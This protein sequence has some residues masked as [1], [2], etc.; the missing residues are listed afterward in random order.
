MENKKKHLWLILAI[1]GVVLL[2]FL[3]GAFLFFK[4]I[5]PKSVKPEVYVPGIYPEGVSFAE[6]EVDEGLSDQERYDAYD[7]NNDPAHPVLDVKVNLY[8]SNLGSRPGTARPQ[9]IAGEYP[10]QITPPSVTLAPTPT[11][12]PAPSVTVAPG[13]VVIGP[14]V[15]L[16]A[17]EFPD[18]YI[19][20]SDIASPQFTGEKYALSWEYTAG[21]AVTFTV[22][23]SV[24]GGNVF[25]ELMTGLER[26]EYELTF[27]DTPG[28][29]CILRVTAMVDSIEYLTADTGNFELV[30]KAQPEPTLINDY[31]DPQV[32]YVDLPDIRISS[33]SGLPVWFKIENNAENAEKLVW[34]LS[35]VPFWGT[36]ES[37]GNE[38]GIIASGNLD[39][40]QGGEFPVDLNALCQELAKPDAARSP[41]APF[42]MKQ[43]IYDFY[44]RVVAFDKDGNCIGDPGRGLSFSYG[45]ADVVADLNSTSF[46]DNSQISTLIYSMYN[47][48]WQWKRVVPGVLNRDLTSPSD[49]VMFGGL[50]GSTEGSDIIKRAVQVELQ[51]ATSP[52]SNASVLGLTNPQGLVYNYLDT[53][54]DIG[55]S[56]SGYNYTTPYFHGLEYDKFVPSQSDLEAMGGIYYYVRAVFYVP[57]SENPSILHPYPSETMTVAFRVTT[58][59][60]NQVEQVVV[61]SDIPFVEF[62]LYS[63][64]RW[65]D[66]NSDEYFEVTRHI[67]A[68]EMT[69][70][71]KNT[72]TGD[73]LLP[74]DT[75]IA[76]YHW[77][78]EQ[79]QAKLDEMLPVYASFRY[80][81]SEPAGFWNEFFSLLEAIYSSVQE[82]YAD[83]KD[84]VV[85]LVDYIPL[86]GDDAKGYLKTAIR[87]T[88]D[89]GLASIGLPPSL[90]NLDKLAED[91]LD[92]CLEVAVDEALRQAGVPADSEA[93]KEITEKVREEVTSGLMDELTKA[94]LAQSQNP[95]NVDFLRV[96]TYK[97]YSPAYVNVFVKNYSDT[98]ESASGRL[99][100]SFGD[101]HDRVYSST[102]VVI[103]SLMPGDSMVIRVYLDHQRYKYVEYEEYFNALYYGTSGE[104]FDIH[105]YTIFDLKDVRVAAKE[106]GL[107]PAPLPALTEYVYD[108][109]NYDFRR[110]FIPAEV[111]WDEDTSVDPSDYGADY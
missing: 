109:N 100:M 66:P 20:E 26:K 70:S 101:D 45:A 84:A 91:G 46:A 50:D 75:H 18:L 42:L 54:P 4:F 97:L 9:D 98:E 53:A 19:H 5:Q 25:T 86:I 33:A 11:P 64:V 47:Y 35:K 65:E 43:E 37:F 7:P 89:Y 39:M 108:H 90:P 36:K 96:N 77:T 59:Q 87:Y 52:F 30:E 51:V 72:E 40:T 81:K 76:T 29:K 22:S 6:I 14:N 48:Q 88:I 78:R 3:L 74:Y 17:P 10:P 80:L 69:F 104:P 13:S 63:P 12:T 110:D 23:L 38:A 62:L 1:I 61:R 94:L 60:Q 107:A 49:T 56:L 106:Q 57:D 92:Y 31:V 34:Q 15:T 95:F 44:I 2:L 85:N 79:Y 16:P 103:P 102:G 27:P 32:Q 93:A 82:A 73:F 55:E 21:R 83:A 68:E 8:I 24:D 111:I 58:A 28:N 71:I 41:E 99:G 105:V 67:E